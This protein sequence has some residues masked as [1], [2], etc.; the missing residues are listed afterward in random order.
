M[1]T[2]VLAEARDLPIMIPY[3]THWKRAAD[4]LSA[5]FS[6][7]VR[8]KTLSKATLALALD[9][10]T[11]HFLIRGKRLTDDQAIELMMGITCECQLKEK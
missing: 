5:D 6:V 1:M 9:F 10:D 3:H 7:S 4:I 2:R 11:L 8:R